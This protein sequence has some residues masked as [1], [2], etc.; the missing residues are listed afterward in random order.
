MYYLFTGSSIST[1]I[2]YLQEEVS[3]HVLI[4]YRK[5]YQYM[6]YLF[7]GSS[8]STCIIYLQKLVLVHVLFIYRK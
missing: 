6:Y 5:K 7:T 8:I 4:I 1:C 2:I 3:V